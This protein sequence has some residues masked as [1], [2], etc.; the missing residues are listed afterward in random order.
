MY[1]V[2]VV[3]V[4]TSLLGNYGRAH[5]DVVAGYGLGG[6]ERLGFDD[7]RQ[8]VICERM[9][10]LSRLLLDYVMVEGERA[11]AE[12]SSLLRAVRGLGCKPE[13]TYV[14][15]YAT[16]TCN[17]RL[18][19]NVIAEYLRSRGFMVRTDVIRAARNEDELD[20][21]M[22]ELIDKVLREAVKMMGR[23]YMV[24]SNATPGFKVESAYLTVASLLAGVEC[25][26]YMHEAFQ[27]VVYMPT[28]P[29]EMR[30]EYLE[31]LAKIKEMEDQKQT[32]I[33]QVIAKLSKDYGKQAEGI[34]EELR[35]RKLV[36]IRN[37]EVTLKKW[38]RSLLEL[39]L[40]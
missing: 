9:G 14:Y 11:S 33:N 17:S 10:E 12:L 19:M 23:G 4:G 28:P 21:A 40:A 32:S 20:E 24:C 18:A 1:C 36:T 25:V 15:L 38:V 16:N 29:L 37:G 2:H 5:P 39:L 35:E 27:D 6:W 22:S 8:L 30:R 26:Y 34:V 13:A 31:I 7:P 3:P